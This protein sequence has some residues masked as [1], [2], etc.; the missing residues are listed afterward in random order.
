[1][2][3]YIYRYVIMYIHGYSSLWY[4]WDICLWKNDSCDV[5][6]EYSVWMQRI[7]P[8]SPTT[9]WLCQNSE[10]EHHHLF[11]VGKSWKI[12]YFYGDFPVR[13][14]DVTRGYNHLLPFQRENDDKPCDET[15]Y[16]IFS[17]SA[18]L[19]KDFWCR[20]LQRG[21]DITAVHSSQFRHLCIHWTSSKKLCLERE[22]SIDNR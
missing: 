17:Q 19:W 6:D 22:I 1:M 11:I 13:Y 15:G 4:I 2:Y 16:H 10:L 3:I 9:L 20:H 12:H 8:I 5:L 21:H 7:C 18:C 14:F